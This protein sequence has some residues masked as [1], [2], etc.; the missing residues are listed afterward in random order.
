MKKMLKKSILFLLCSVLGGTFLMAQGFV[1]PIPIPEL[2]DQDLVEL[3]IDQTMHNFNP[4]GTDSLNTLIPAYGYNVKGQASSTLLGPT[5]A[6]RYGHQVNSKITNNLPVLTTVHWHGAHIPV[7]TDGGPH[8]RIQPGETWD[9]NFE[10]KDKSSTMWYHPHA[11]DITYEQVQLGLAGMIYVEDPEGGDAILSEIHQ[12][13]PTE[14]GVN[15]FP[16]IVQTKQFG[17]DTTGQQQIKSTLDPG[18]KDNFSYLVNGVVDP[19]LELPASMVRLRML[20]GDGKFA[21]NFGLEDEAGNRDSFQLIA[22]D[23]GYTDRSYKLDT[24]IMAGGERTEWLLDLRGR[25]G[26]ILYL[27]NYSATIPEGIIGGPK[28]NV[29][30]RKADNPYFDT[31]TRLLKITVGESAG[32]PS[33]IISF[34]IPLHPSEAPPLSEV[35]NTRLKTLYQS[36]IIKSVGD[37]TKNIYN[38][39]KILMDTSVIN[40]T[41]FLNTTELWTIDNQ[42]NAA[43]PW[44]IHDTHFWVTKI[45]DENDNELD[46]SL[47]PEIFAGPLDNV[48]IRAGWKL[49]YIIQFKDY[50]TPAKASLTYM[51]HCH[52][53]PHED[54][55]MMHQW[56]V[57]TPELLTSVETPLPLDFPFKL[58]P[59]PAANYLY[60]ESASTTTSQIRFFDLSGRLLQQ[61]KVPA[62]DGTTQISLQGLPKGMVFM[63]W[64]ME[65]GVVTRKVILE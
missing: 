18:Y 41:V 57:T 25:E 64:H 43:H 29:A 53:L 45:I 49:D 5:I 63:E 28:P 22:T 60:L 48:L 4:N 54:R 47:Y 50:A 16:I 11:F 3:T 36:R 42:T 9:I 17:S 13:L 2:I 33:P 31:N 46:K 62:F 34:P 32:P 26:D 38:I 52:I 65:K 35:S 27:M 61:Q 7:D 56:V 39:D 20:N 19:S 21:F 6:W 30:K 40:D 58:Y 51:Y 8:Q 10:I 37:T 15:D 12:I 59:N 24:I 44:H 1:N 23:G 55:G 14:Y